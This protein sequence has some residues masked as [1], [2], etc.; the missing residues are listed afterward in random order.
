MS[1]A[2]EIDA[3]APGYQLLSDA[4]S[5]ALDNSRP[6]GSIN[7][8][9]EWYTLAPGYYSVS[10]AG[11]DPAKHAP[12]RMGLVGFAT[13]SKKS[14]NDIN[15]IFTPTDPLIEG[16]SQGVL[17]KQ[18][19]TWKSWQYSIADSPRLLKN[20]TSQKKTVLVIGSSVAA[21]YNVPAGT[22]YIAKI[23]ASL[24]ATHTFINH[25]VPGSNTTNWATAN[26]YFS[27]LEGVMQGTRADFV[28]I[29]LN[30]YNQGLVGSSDKPGVWR[31][32]IRGL[33]EFVAMAR[34]SGV[35]PV[36]VCSYPADAFT[37]E[38]AVY[39]QSANRWFA[40]QDFLTV[41]FS[42]VLDDGSA[43]IISIFST[44]DGLHPNE[45]GH[46]AMSRTFPLDY[47]KS[48][49]SFIPVR[50]AMTGEGTLI[51]SGYDI[52]PYEIQQ[53]NVSDFTFSIDIKKGSVD[54]DRMN[55]AVFGED[56]YNLLRLRLILGH[57]EL[58]WNDNPTAIVSSHMVS[59]SAY[60]TLTVRFKRSQ[61]KL[62]LWINGS[63]I[64]EVTT[65]GTWQPDISKIQLFMLSG[66]TFTLAQAYFR[67]ILLYSTALEDTLI[68]D[69]AKGRIPNS[70]LIV[71]A[72][73][74]DSS[75]VKRGYRLT[76]LA[77]SRAE[78][79]TMEDA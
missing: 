27:S 35:V 43:H 23:A 65:P 21:G 52:P 6:I 41:N 36:V 30:L 74:D 4:D 1:L 17:Q 76:N 12:T 25:S 39:Y 75:P 32:Y 7:Q 67:N 8:S 20:K 37:T 15:I 63:M 68:K 57:V 5:A 29:A 77:P 51:P 40:Y 64:G 54:L 44:G 73:F 34:S 2:S 42:Q 46:L 62:S 61:S 13:V 16:F 48:A 49:P 18:G 3:Q 70:N 26:P 78:V 71:N 28:I 22:G 59:T 79:V 9:T 60:S 56:R 58:G 66:Y 14:D 38:D 24:S 10:A 19:G 55:P 69:I 53:I 50:R 31:S 45:A 72:P 33:E 11:W 47:F